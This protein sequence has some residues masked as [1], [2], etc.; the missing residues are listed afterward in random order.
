MTSGQG[1]DSNANQNMQ[2]G[3]Q[4]Q[5]TSLPLVN[6]QSASSLQSTADRFPGVRDGRQLGRVFSDPD[7]RVP[8]MV[9]VPMGAVGGTSPAYQDPGVPAKCSV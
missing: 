7:T 9:N 6:P 1:S 5:A 8:S 4:Q 3:F 2:P